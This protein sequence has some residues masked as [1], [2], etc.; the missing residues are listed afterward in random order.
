MA[1]YPTAPDQTIT[2]MWSN[3]A[4]GVNFAKQCKQH[5]LR[6]HHTML[7]ALL[8]ETFILHRCTFHL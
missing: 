3:G 5:T 6:L 1:K 7:Q 8:C 2:Q 4:R